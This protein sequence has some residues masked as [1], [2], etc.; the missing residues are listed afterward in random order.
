MEYDVTIGLEVHVQVRTESKMFCSCPN[1]SL[2]EP[3]TLTCPVCMGYPGVLP[4]PNEEAIRKTRLAG[5]MLMC[6]VPACSKFD[7]K[8]YFY[9]DM[10]KNYQI[11]QFDMPLCLGGEVAIGGKA[12]S[13]EVEPTVIG[14]TRIHLEEDVAKSS[15]RGRDSGIDFNRAG[16]PLMEVV[17][18]PDMSSA[19]EAYLYLV[20]LKQVM[21]YTGISDCDMEKGQMRCDVNVS[22]RPRGAAELNP[23]TEVKNLNSFKNV[24]RAIDHEVDRQIDELEDGI[25]PTQT[26]RGWNADSGETYL[27]RRK[28]TSD[29]YRYFPDPDLMPLYIDAAALAALREEMPETPVARR[30]R[31]VADYGLPTYDAHVLTLEKPVSDYFEAGI[32]AGAE[33]KPLSNWIMVELLRLLGAAEV[34]ISVCRVSPQQLAELLAL[35]QRAPGRKCIN[36]KIAKTVFEEMFESGQDPVPII[37]ARDLWEED[38]DAIAGF[39]EQA[40]AANPDPVRQYREGKEQALN[41]LVGQVMKFS[42]GKANPQSAREALQAALQ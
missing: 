3:N 15:H 39:V 25:A 14:L 26:T 38:D 5:L 12:L 36:G 10:P 13:G 37:D 18:E 21:Q 32:A 41:F 22:V 6:E 16:V 23:K 2:A 33:A 29:D 28:E 20:A 1:R 40:I 30:A 11:S 42:R 17:S 31:F 9:P 34:D 19:D 35:T 27:L 4:V 24:H 8:S 7:R